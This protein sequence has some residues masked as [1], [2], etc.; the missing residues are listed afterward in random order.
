M[1]SKLK[2]YAQRF[3]AQSTRERA[4]IAFSLIA[5]IGFIWWSYYATPIQKRIETV[6]AE[7][8]RI[9]R[10][11]ENSQTIM[12]EIRQTI[13]QGVHREKEAQLAKLNK[14]LAGLEDQLRLT[15]I[16]LVDPEKMFQLM[17]QLIYRD[18]R[19][20]LLSLK[21]REV[22]PAIPAVNEE[23]TE[24]PGIYR[25]V[26]EI[27]FAG[28]Y[29]DILQYMQKLEALDWKLLWDE[30]EIVSDDHP[31]VTVKVAISTLSTRK[32]WVGI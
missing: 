26:L 14:D 9:G 1:N 7:N 17:N 15:T 11:V 30:I 29:L 20:K 19:L 4:L 32:E 21:R 22:K 2:Q 23:D 3:D 8:E 31:T 18:S 28:K 24:E 10:E 27:E 16:E 6:T 12:R 5:A 25:H 13:A